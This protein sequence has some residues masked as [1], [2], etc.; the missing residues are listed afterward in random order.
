MTIPTTRRF[1]ATA[2]SSWPACR[3]QVSPSGG[4]SLSL[5]LARYDP[6]GSLDS[7]FGIS[8]KVVIDDE[9]ANAIALQ[10]DGK[11]VVAGAGSAS[12]KSVLL[13]QRFMPNGT[14]DTGFGEYGSATVR[15][16]EPSAAAGIAIAPDGKI[17][18]AGGFIARFSKSGL[19]DFGFGHNVLLSGVVAIRHFGAGKVA[20]PPDGKIVAA[21]GGGRATEVIRVLPDRSSLLK[22]KR[23]GHGRGMVVSDPPGIECGLLGPSADR[24]RA[25]VCSSLFETGSTVKL[26]ILHRRGSRVSWRGAC[27]GSSHSCTVTI[28]GD[29]KLTVTFRKP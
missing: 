7:S 6:D 1:N 22:I 19:P 29:R 2:R 20:V 25:R 9:T 21:G 14:L 28:N 8:G 12:S 17:V 24:P 11:I 5:A 23:L 3:R 16:E 18:A 13:V 15:T 10:P 4:A 27:T 26:I